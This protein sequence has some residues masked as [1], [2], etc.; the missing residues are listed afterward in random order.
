[1]AFMVCS[2]RVDAWVE[3]IWLVP[4]AVAEERGDGGGEGEGRD[5]LDTG[6]GEEG[7]HGVSFRV[8]EL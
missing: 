5:E 1:M 4:V 3:A 7:L 8:V 2:L 6:A